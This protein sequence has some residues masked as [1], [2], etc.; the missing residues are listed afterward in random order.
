M[1]N[2]DPTKWEY[3]ENKELKDFLRMATYYKEK[4]Q[5]LKEQMDL[6]KQHNR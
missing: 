5:D 2:N 6:M 4:Q 3:F 1:S